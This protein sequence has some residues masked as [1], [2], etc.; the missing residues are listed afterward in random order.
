MLVVLS[1]L[2]FS[3]AQSTKIGD[4]RFNKNL[5]VETYQAYFSELNQIAVSNQIP[6]LDLV[7]AGDI[8]ELSRSAFWFESGERP[9]QD[10]EAIE[11]GSLTEAT[12]LKIIDAITRE[13]KVAETLALF[14]Q[15]K[16]LFA[17]DV[18][19]HY[20]L[21]NHD[22]LINATPQIRSRVRELFGL[23]G[24]DTLFDHQF[25]FRTGDGTAF[26][27][28]R[29]GHEYDPMN[30]SVDTHAMEV[31]PTEFPETVYGTA[32]LGDI[33]TIEFGAA[34][35]YY[36]IAEYGEEAIQQDP[37]LMALYE[38]LMGFDDVR[39]TTALL[40][41]IFSTPGVKKRQTWDYMAPCFRR[42]TVTLA[43][44][45]R[46]VDGITRASTLSASQR[47]LL[48]GL[49]NSNLLQQGVPYWM[50]K[51]LMKRVSKEIKLSSQVR[52]AKRDALVKD[53]NSGCKCVIS[54]HTHFPEVSLMSAKKGDERYYINTGTW[55]NV[56][57][58][59]KNFKE[60]GRLKAM[61]KV[62][63]FR[64]SEK[65]DSSPD[66]SS[67]S[68]HFLSGVSFGNHRHL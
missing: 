1:D 4:L 50:V 30:F 45:P 15:I 56:I 52:W 29:H 25:L 12:I 6:K 31:I 68:F 40:A 19:L 5:P 49:L 60:F 10:N 18:E 42:L 65:S 24:G 43:E 27:L 57:P 46:F 36:F 55:R 7:L 62:I 20:I 23:P 41:Y 13:E 51:Q 48:R 33:T 8:L 26:C 53:Q 34:L 37:I 67:W 35:P 21:G 32:S 2:H 16:G 38:R 66:G 17:V 22:R 14:R 3:E 54:G 39:P 58:A 28:V 47:L 63:V 64:P 44:N 9:Y 61:A 59:T 11:P